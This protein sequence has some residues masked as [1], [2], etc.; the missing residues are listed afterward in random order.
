MKQERII[1]N[2]QIGSIKVDP[3]KVITF[4]EGVLGFEEIHEYVIIDFEEHEP[5]QWLVALN[6][7]E[8]QFPI[9]SPILVKEDYSPSLAREAVSQIGDFADK[10]LL[11][12]AIVTIKPGA[13][14]VTADLKGP[15]II[16]QKTRLG[17]QII[18][19]S[20]EYPLD[21]PVI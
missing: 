8:V 14:R 18:L 11:L 6:D 2:R 10:D 4:P 5:F 21:H 17:K 20:D 7:P 12:Y 16:N 15:L 9:I 3:S 13:T 19:D 1:N